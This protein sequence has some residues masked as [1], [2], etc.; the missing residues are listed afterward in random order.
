VD[1]DA[2]ERSDMETSWVEGDVDD[3]ETE[4]I[5]MEDLTGTPG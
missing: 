3:D 4:R 2:D 1:D 5:G